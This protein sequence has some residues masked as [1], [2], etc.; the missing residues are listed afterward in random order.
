MM[1]FK[2]CILMF[3]DKTKLVQTNAIIKITKNVQC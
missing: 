1:F 2:I 3:K